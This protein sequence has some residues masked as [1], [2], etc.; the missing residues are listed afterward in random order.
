GGVEGAT[1]QE[2]VGRLGDRRRLGQDL[3]EREVEVRVAVPVELGRDG[4]CAEPGGRAAG[5]ADRAQRRELGLAVEAVARLPLERRRAVTTHPAAVA[6]DRRAQAVLAG[7]P[8]R[9]NRREDAAAPRME[10]LVPGARGTEGELLDTVAAER[11]MRVAVDEAGDRAPSP[12]VDL[13]HVAVERRQVAHAADR[14]DRVA[15][16]EDERILD[17]VDLAERRS[18]QGRAATRR[19]RDLREVADE[20]L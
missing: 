16:A 11:R 19:C 1:L 4:V 20:E 8:G 7:G 15:V 18:A 3:G 6:L 10:L 9:P 5:V 12:P 2:D 14:A 17:D 13:D